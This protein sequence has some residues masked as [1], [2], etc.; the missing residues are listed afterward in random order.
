MRLFKSQ[1]EKQQIAAARDE[2]EQFIETVARA[3]P[4]QVRTVAQEFQSNHNLEALSSKEKTR[5]RDQAFRT[6]AD[7]V[8]ADDHLTIDEE[9]A[10]EEVMEA[11]GVGPAEAGGMFL[12]VF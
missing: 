2:Y 4:S 11:L 12:G 10:F 8:L 1:E 6:Y 5:L 7:N 9:M 3:E